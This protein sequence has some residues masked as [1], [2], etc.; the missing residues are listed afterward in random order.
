MHRRERV[1]VNH[2]E[3]LVESD[4]ASVAHYGRVLGWRHVQN[5][6]LRYGVDNRRARRLV[7]QVNARS[8]RVSR[9]VPVEMSTVTRQPVD[10]GVFMKVAVVPRQLSDS[11]PVYQERLTDV[12]VNSAELVT[13]SGV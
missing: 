3:R 10:R 8:V 9:A 2:V 12:L 1:T 7:Q 5:D 6:L 4:V 13:A 11:V